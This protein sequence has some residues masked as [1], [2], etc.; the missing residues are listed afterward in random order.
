MRRGGREGEG[1]TR[2][3]ERVKGKGSNVKR[4]ALCKNKTEMGLVTAKVGAAGLARSQGPST[5]T[6]RRLG[7]SRQGKE[8]L[9]NLG[10]G[11]GWACF[12]KDSG[13]GDCW[14]AKDLPSFPGQA[15]SWGRNWGS[16]GQVSLLPQVTQ[17]HSTEHRAWHAA[18][19]K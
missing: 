5:A 16:G 7:H 6:H 18:V 13:L 19:N 1:K 14:T 15:R 2:K 4:G 8:W 3:E 9:V 17:P 10:C 11:G 12:S